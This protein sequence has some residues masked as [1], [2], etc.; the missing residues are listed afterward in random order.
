MELAIQGGD[1]KVIALDGQFCD[2]FE[3]L[4]RALPLGPGAR[5]ELLLDLPPI[6]G[7]SCKIVLRG[8]TE[9]PDVTLLED[10]GRRRAQADGAADPRAAA[11][12]AAAG[13]NPAG[14]GETARSRHRGR[15]DA[16]HA[17]ELQ[18]R[19]R[20]AAKDLVDQRQVLDRL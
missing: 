14:A 9:L 18:A 1:L 4:Q 13:A 11:Q 5:C 15:R 10:P 19:R 12:S 7:Q 2:P 17:R 8:E 3:P 6:A 16:I 20:G